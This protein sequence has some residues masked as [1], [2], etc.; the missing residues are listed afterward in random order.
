M[1]KE[2]I[3]NLALSGLMGALVLLLTYWPHIPVGNGYVHMGDTFIY[4]AAVLLPLPYGLAVAT[5]GAALADCLSGFALWAPATIVIKG[6]T[7]L[8]FTS[9]SDKLLCLRNQLAPIGAGVLCAG[10]YYLY[11]A[12][13]YGNYIAPL[14]SIPGNL[15][16]SLVSGVVFYIKAMA[17]KKRKSL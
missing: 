16:Q 11:E 7:V 10:G 3:R 13:L 6:L 15:I 1:K 9:K 12:V 8:L 5:A 2:S 4:L 17:L 14:T